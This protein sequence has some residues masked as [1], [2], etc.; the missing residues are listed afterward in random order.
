MQRSFCTLKKK[1]FYQKKFIASSFLL[2]NIIIW[3][4][5]FA[6]KKNHLVYFSRLQVV[7]YCFCGIS[8][9]ARYPSASGS[10]HLFNIVVIN[11]AAAIVLWRFPFERHMVFKDVRNLKRSCKKVFDM[12]NFKCF[13]D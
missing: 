9:A 6:E 12:P 11:W 2:N 5:C 3:Y 8:S 4:K 13:L 7:Y 1:S 10:V